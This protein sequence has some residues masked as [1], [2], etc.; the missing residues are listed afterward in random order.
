M[1][2]HHIRRTTASVVY[3]KAAKN[4]EQNRGLAAFRIE[5][6]EG[7]IVDGAADVGQTQ[8]PSRSRF[9]KTWPSPKRY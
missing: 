1:V 2:L 7:S 4:E 6:P 3:A 5:M 9:S 8:Q